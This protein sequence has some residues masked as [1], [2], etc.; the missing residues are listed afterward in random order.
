MFSK[1]VNYSHPKAMNKHGRIIDIIK[2]RIRWNFFF[3]R[4]VNKNIINL[5]LVRKYLNFIQN[6]YKYIAFAS[7]YFGIGKYYISKH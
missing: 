4:I 5:E 3:L 6:S 1:F 7:E 2:I